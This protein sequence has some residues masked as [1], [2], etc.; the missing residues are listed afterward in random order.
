MT[1][2]TEDSVKGSFHEA[3]GTIKEGLGRFADDCG[4]EAEGNVE[5]NAGK[6]QQ[7]I[8]HAKEIVEQL[9]GTLAAITKDGN[10]S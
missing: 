3:K 1:S 7:Q 10:A 6:L 4:L 2:S 8:G 9:K 5:K